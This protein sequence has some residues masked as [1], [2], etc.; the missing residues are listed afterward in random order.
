MEQ[1]VAQQKETLEQEGW[2][3]Q[4]EDLP[5]AP[6]NIYIRVKNPNDGLIYAAYAPIP[7]VRMEMSEDF[8]GRIGFFSGVIWAQIIQEGEE[9]LQMVAAFALSSDVFTDM[10]AAD[11]PLTQIRSFDE[12]IAWLKQLTGN[13]PE[14]NELIDSTFEEITKEEFYATPS[15]MTLRASNE[16][17]ELPISLPDPLG[18]LH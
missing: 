16:K 12:F 17:V 2:E 8:G 5:D 18:L 7:V 1:I 10:F 9:L 3:F 14:T 4:S 6:S 13:D 15:V 11:M